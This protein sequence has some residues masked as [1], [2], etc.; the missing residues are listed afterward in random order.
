MRV[1]IITHSFNSLA[2]RLHVELR[3]R[4][5]EVSV[6][7]DINDAVTLQAAELFQPDIVLAPFLKRRLPETLIGRL[8]C[9]IVHPG[10]EGDRGPA[11]LD[12]AILDQRTEWGVT[13]LQATGEFDAGP[14]W[15]SAAYA[16]RPARKSSLYLRETGMAATQAVL[17]AIERIGRGESPRSLDA[18]TLAAGWR[19]P[20]TPAVRAVDWERDDT[21]TVLRKVASADGMPGCPAV[22]CGKPVRLFN[23]RTAGSRSDASPGALIARSG[24][25]L[26]IATLDG[27]VW[28]GHL[29]DKASTHPFKLPAALVLA[30]E[31]TGLSDVDRGSAGGFGDIAYAEHGRVGVLSF[32]FY[33]GAMGTDACRRLL[34]AWQHAVSRNTSVLVLAGFGDHWSNGLD[35]NAIEAA[36]S[37][38][39][40]SYANIE[41][42]DDLAEAIIRTTDRLT[43]SAVGGNAGAGGVFL[44]RAADMVWLRAGVILNPH[45]KDMGNLYGSEFWTYLLPRH[46]GTENAARISAARLPM[47]GPEACRLGLAERLI[48]VSFDEFPG[49]VL[50]DALDLAESEDLITRI[51]NKQRQRAADEAHKPLAAYRDEE[52]AHMRRNFYGFDTSYHIARSNFVRKIA[53][54]RTPSILAAHRG[55]A[56]RQRGIPA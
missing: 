32:D 31:V 16:M 11:A 52:L 45:Y 33:N 36:S 10:P 43:I 37:P 55:A 34:A 51:E 26:C 6:E 41:A 8:T 29:L 44:A 17:D 49:R 40:E 53:K 19:G 50:A 1:L 39:D 20:V 38:A 56:L 18:A 2:Q 14:V 24:Q 54:A 28:I 15:A 47:G 23:A 3:E 42:M 22:L 25:A 48:E 30:K 12:H 9:L 46:A 27:A 7:L 35:L 5:H 4:G 13:V 21:A